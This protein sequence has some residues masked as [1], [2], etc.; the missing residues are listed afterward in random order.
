MQENQVEAGRFGGDSPAGGSPKEWKKYGNGAA[1][2][3]GK[4]RRARATAQYEKDMEKNMEKTMGPMDNSHPS[5]PSSPSN[6]KR[7]EHA[8]YAEDSRDNQKYNTTPV[9]NHGLPHDSQ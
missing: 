8:S 5:A 4:T 6:F 3:N 1:R 7:G 2:P 9:D